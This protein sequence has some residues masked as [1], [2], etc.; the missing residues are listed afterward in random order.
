[1]NWMAVAAKDLS[2]KYKSLNKE[3][4]YDRKLLRK[5]FEDS[6]AAIEELIDRSW[7]EDGT[8]KGFKKGLIPFI[9]YLIAHDAHHRGHAMLTL[10]QCGLKL[11]D[12]LKW[13]LWEWY[14]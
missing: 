2:K 6:G 4:P 7:E 12:V 10:K 14:K 9:A 5:S 8:M 13:G 1:M 3:Q 11:P